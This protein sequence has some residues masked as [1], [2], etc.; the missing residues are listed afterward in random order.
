MNKIKIPLL[1]GI[2]ILLSSIILALLVNFV[3]LGNFRLGLRA[4]SLFFAL[5][6]IATIIAA[7]VKMFKK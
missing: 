7:I 6:G 1:S 3:E 4:L 5:V 2:S